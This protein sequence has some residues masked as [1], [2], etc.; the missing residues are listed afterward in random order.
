MIVT[1]TLGLKD[2]MQKAQFGKVTARSLVDAVTEELE[3]A[4]M[5]G[6]LAPGER[7]SEQGLAASM[8]VSRG[9]LREAIR[10]LEGRRLLERKVN[11][12]VRVVELS[13][14]RLA[15]LLHVREALEGMG[16]R[17]ACER[18]TDAELDELGAMIE[19]HAATIDA[20]AGA[21]YYQQSGDFDV[22]FRIAKASG[23]DMLI[24]MICGDLYDLLRVYRYKSSTMNGRAGAA[25]AEH[26]AIVAALK[27]R[28]PEAA[29]RMMRTHISNGRGYALMALEQ[30]AKEALRDQPA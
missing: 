14:E 26:R 17:L 21:S 16:A 25:L 6:R 30:A 27:S 18:L 10:R 28:D 8:G 23:N 12:G 24:S 13:V 1:F 4:I 7:I 15:N 20:Q 19:D 5:E 9:P 11:V 22:H 3:S 29:E 2:S